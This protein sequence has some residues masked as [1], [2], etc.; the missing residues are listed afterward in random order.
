[1]L[2]PASWQ[3]L[4]GQ[5]RSGR[6]AVLSVAA[7]LDDPER[8]A[9][10]LGDDDLADLDLSIVRRVVSVVEPG[11]YVADTTLL[12]N[13][14]L[15][16][17][18]ASDEDVHAAARATGMAPW[19]DTL[20]DGLAT[21]VGRLGHSLPKAERIRLGIARA[22]LSESPVVV[23]DDPT[24]TL[25]REA[26]EE[27]W[28][29]M[30]SLFADRAVLIA[31]TR[32]DL[33][34]ADD[35]VVVLADGRIA[36][37]GTVDHLMHHGSHW[38]GLWSRHS[39]GV[40]PVQALREFPS[41][42]RL[43]Q[44]VLERSVRRLTTETFEA[45]EVVFLTGEPS[46][47]LFLIVRGSVELWDAERRVATLHDGDHFGEFDPLV[48]T[49]SDARRPLTARAATTA[50][51]R[52]LHRNAL[53]GGASQVLDGSTEHRAV[54]RLLAR[55]GALGLAD[56]QR[57]MPGVDV[58]TVLDELLV[59]GSITR[60]VADGVTMWRIAG[61]ARRATNQRAHLLE[62]LERPG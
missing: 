20:P 1:V 23:I 14:R 39:G 21:A 46:D 42:A 19:L 30:R 43:P 26:A 59:G 58:D 31:T 17:P 61:E 57:E 29:T 37:T 8:G 2:Q 48:D 12:E 36:E 40:D 41:L 9:V 5:Q 15:S 28:R 16:R 35:I 50:T 13:L 34:D 6:R 45:G 32:L 60:S 38:S 47:R 33:V 44:S 4:V 51:L 3:V 54:Y 49:A 11:T 18:E 55:S 25:D 10:R 62:L 52:S 22:V 24:D 27:C 53:T 56:I 7:G